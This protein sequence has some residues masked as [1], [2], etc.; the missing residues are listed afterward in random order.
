MELNRCPKCDGEWSIVS[1][2]NRPSSDRCGMRY[3]P[4]LGTLWIN[5]GVYTITWITGI[6]CRIAIGSGTLGAVLPLL[7]YTVTEEQLAKYLILI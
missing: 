5:I 2:Y 7:A 4:L 1:T 3:Y 6:G